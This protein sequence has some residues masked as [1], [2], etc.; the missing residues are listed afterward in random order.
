VSGNIRRSRL[1]PRDREPLTQRSR[2]VYLVFVATEDTHA[3]KQY[4]DA[5][6]QQGLVDRSRVEIVA[7]PTR[8]GRSS[9]GALVDRL[10]AHRDALDTRLEQ[11]EYWA[12]FDV[13]HQASPQ[14]L[15][16]FTEAVQVARSRGH[17][18]AGSNPCFE[19]WLL[20]HVSADV[21]GIPSATD[22]RQAADL[23]EQRL[24]D[25]LLADG[26]RARGYN[27]ARIEAE[28]FATTERVEAA[29][30]RARALLP[31][32]PE[33]WPSRVGTHVHAVI[34]RLP[35]PPAARPV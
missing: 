16:G 4:L 10:K 17:R 2:D 32:T 27:K 21:T 31:A 22:D 30:E 20:L 19:L 1:I 11:D 7:L 15:R 23:C 13:D 24:R 3:A 18:L 25:A 28:R 12:V 33:P 6:Q 14:N 8:D 9:L 29:C 35:R 34:E 26:E 5:L